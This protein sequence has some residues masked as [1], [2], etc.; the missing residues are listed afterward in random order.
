LKEWAT[1]ENPD[2]LF[3]QN[4]SLDKI[5]LRMLFT[6]VEWQKLLKFRFYECRMSKLGLQ[7]LNNL[8][9]KSDKS[10][11]NLE[12]SFNPISDNKLFTIFLQDRFTCLTLRCN[13]LGPKFA[14]EAEEN[15]SKLSKMEYLNLYGNKLNDEG[16]KLVF[17]ALTEK[18]Q[19]KTIRAIDLGRNELTNI[20]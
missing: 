11:L 13:E 2:E 8:F 14:K 3:V 17:D 6:L 18:S 12:I 7:F 9:V 4:L 10:N 20:D 1:K 5:T 15:L 19:T 16:A